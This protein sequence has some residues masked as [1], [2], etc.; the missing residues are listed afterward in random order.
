MA[1]E[2]VYYSSDETGAPVL[3][4]VAGSMI[5][6]LDACLVDGYNAKSVT[7]IVVSGGV[8]T[9]TI[10]AH[11][12]ETGRIYEF[13]GAS[14]SGLNG[15]KKITVTD[16]NAVT[17][18]ATG[19]SNQTASGTITGKRPSLGWTKPHAAT[20]K[21]IYQ[22]T[23]P[24]ATAM[25][26]RVDDTGSGVANP[27]WARALMLESATGID[28]Y[29]NERPSSAQL[30]GG[31]YWSKG[32]N[33]SSA[34]SWILV[35]DGRTFYFWT[36]SENDTL[37]G[38]GAL[39][40]RMF[41]DIT[42]YRA[43]DAYACMLGGDHGSNGSSAANVWYSLGGTANAPSLLLCRMADAIGFG[44]CAAW[45]GP[46]SGST[47]GNSGPA[48]PSPVDNGMVLVPRM[49]VSEY[50]ATFS[51]P[52]RG[53]ARGLMAPAANVGNRLHKRVLSNVIDFPGDVLMV[54][55]VANASPGCMAVDLTGPWG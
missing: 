41:G 38:T 5:G 9:A 37:S 28:A 19:I 17:F 18:D 36:E 13:A 51:Q 23:D 48:Y 6:V 30:S 4:N 35:G 49:L 33:T 3:N 44:P 12:L 45:T 14:P 43:G 22:R 32:S 7:S 25:L 54:G 52:I 24:Q 34:R 31:Q 55:T 26:L 16:S 29:G 8:A 47:I 27:T 50:N 1:N 39:H 42:S 11:G 15:R 20:G 46:G 40:F 53:H 21:A 10:S 2:V